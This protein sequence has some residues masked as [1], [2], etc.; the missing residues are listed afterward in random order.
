MSLP[1]NFICPI[2]QTTMVD[3]VMCEDGISYEKS[4]ILRWLQ[5]NNTSPVTR[6]IISANIIP[7]IALR[8]TIQDY[9]KSQ[10]RPQTNPKNFI[11]PTHTLSYQKS[12]NDVSFII[13]QSSFSYEGKGDVY[14]VVRLKFLTTRK[15]SRKVVAVVDTSGSMDECADIP[16]VESSGLTRLD[17]VKH[18]LNTIVHSLSDFDM[19]CIIKFSNSAEVVSDFI[20]LNRMGKE[21]VLKNIK[22]LQPDCMTNLWAGIKLGIDK[23]NQIYNDDYNI[24]MLV[25]TDGV[26]NSDPPRGIIPTLTEQIRTNKLNF[27]IN[28]FGYGYNIDSNLLNNIAHLGNGIFGFIPDATMVGT[29][30]INMLSSI[31]TGCINNLEVISNIEML[32]PNNLGMISYDQ[33]V[34]LIF[35]NN[36]NTDI[37]I[38]FNSTEHVINIVPIID[39]PTNEDIEQFMR[40]KLI[41]ILTNTI[42]SGKSDILM[43]FKI[44]LEKFNVNLH[45]LYLK[46]L[47]NDIYFDDPNKGQLTKAVS[48]SD[49]FQSWGNHYLKSICRAHQLEKCITF[50]EL[51]PQHYINEQYKNEQNRIEKIFCDLPAPTPSKQKYSYNNTNTTPVSMSNY[52]VQS[53]G[54]FDG[55]GKVRM[56]DPSDNLTYYKYVSEIKSGDYVYCPN[57]NTKYTKIKCV[58]KLKVEKEILMTN[59]NDMK[60]TPYHPVQICKYWE[61]PKNINNPEMTYIDYMYDFILDDYHIVEIN[62]INVITL[63]HKFNF[64]D[65][66]KH[67]YFGDNIISDLETHNDWD[68][69]YIILE[70]YEFVRGDDMKINKLRF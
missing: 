24:S 39:T 25:M 27:T 49:W 44:D 41:K 3:P 18:T 30:F 8:N 17:L 70:D 23:I 13:N 22:R 14:N 52:Y 19:L 38:K 15:K 21:C 32:T 57:K 47:I 10:I 11:N 43:R 55:F 62:D 67:D 63:G 34:H 68:S 33:P 50:K 2:T 9:L 6:Q 28:T 69:G 20:Q 58:L 66:V 35:K 36:N 48:R 42:N 26:S 29:I 51:S 59:I 1:E 60:I 31:L 56:Y 16:G 45:S 65:I 64:N 12:N 46:D 40:V 61:F 7:N 53:G 37:K 54:C 5:N 4:A